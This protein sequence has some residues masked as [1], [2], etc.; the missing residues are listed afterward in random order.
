M[1][2]W[3]TNNPPTHGLCDWKHSPLV[4]EFLSHNRFVQR[5]E[6]ENGLYSLV[7]QVCE[8]VRPQLCRWNKQAQ[9]MMV[10]LAASGYSLEFDQVE[11]DKLRERV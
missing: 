1:E 8:K 11:L 9:T 3:E 7:Q 2:K 5:R 10:R 4:T 6:M